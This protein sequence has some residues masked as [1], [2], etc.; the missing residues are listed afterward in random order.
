MFWLRAKHDSRIHALVRPLSL[1]HPELRL[2]D[3]RAQLVQ[4]RLY[5][6]VIFH[7]VAGDEQ[8]DL[9]TQNLPEGGKS[10]QKLP[11]S[12]KRLM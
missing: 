1:V 7:V 3:D 10:R 2:L 11:R 8:L 12:L 5:L 6:L 9:S 4:V